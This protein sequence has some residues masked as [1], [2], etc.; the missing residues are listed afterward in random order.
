M[1][2]IKTDVTLFLFFVEMRYYA[3]AYVARCVSP[4]IKLYERT[5][6]DQVR[7]SYVYGAGTHRTKYRW[8]VT[9]Q[10]GQ[11]PS[12]HS[13]RNHREAVLA[14][15]FHEKTQRVIFVFLFD[16]LTLRTSRAHP[17]SALSER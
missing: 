9:Q 4:F 1:Y 5:L 8:F 2:V 6:F 14:R 16:S 13:Y 17:S 10:D 7:N 12:C 3:K 11:A 15:I